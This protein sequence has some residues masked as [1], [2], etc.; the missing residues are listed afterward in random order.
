MKTIT[1]IRHATMAN[2]RNHDEQQERQGH[3][4]D[5]IDLTDVQRERNLTS[6]T[7]G[8]RT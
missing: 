1:P 7:S 8:V 2:D 6:Y 3:S 4:M 5:V